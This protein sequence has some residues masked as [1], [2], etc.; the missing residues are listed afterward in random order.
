MLGALV[1]AG[2]NGLREKLPLR[3]PTTRPPDEM[4]HTERTSAGLVRLPRRLSDALALLAQNE[5]M[6]QAMGE[7]FRTAYLMHKS[8]E[9]ESLENY[10]PEEQIARYADAY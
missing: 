7:E 9:I 5:T 6:G 3:E 10:S 8:S 2:L 4:K 1:W